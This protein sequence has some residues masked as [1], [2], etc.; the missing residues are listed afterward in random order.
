MDIDVVK[1]WFS[2]HTVT[3]LNIIIVCMAIAEKIGTHDRKLSQ[4]KTLYSDIV[5]QLIVDTKISIQQ[6]MKLVAQY[7][8]MNKDGLVDDFITIVCDITNN[9]NL[10]NDKWIPDNMVGRVKNRC[11]P[12]RSKNQRNYKHSINRK[13]KR[14]NNKNRFY[15][16]TK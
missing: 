14:K 12:C 9:P 7:N 2:Q 4:C 5:D 13:E 11:F 16:K 10:I 15:P 6:G 3:P 1:E 8:Q